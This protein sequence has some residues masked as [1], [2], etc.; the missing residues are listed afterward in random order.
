MNCK[1]PPNFFFFS[2]FFFFCRPVVFGV[3]GQGSDLSHSCGQHHTC[4]NA[5]SLTHCARP[6]IKPASQPCEEATN[7]IVPQRKLPPSYFYVQS[8]V[9]ENQDSV[10]SWETVN[11]PVTWLRSLIVILIPNLEDNTEERMNLLWFNGT[12]FAFNI[13]SVFTGS[14]EFSY[15]YQNTS[16][17][18]FKHKHIKL[19]S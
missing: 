4:G 19:C 8:Y 2:F 12:Q 3:L 1:D 11:Y 9:Y 15:L 7:P 17:F 14:C 5:R 10:S 13:S 16:I 18:L 6:G